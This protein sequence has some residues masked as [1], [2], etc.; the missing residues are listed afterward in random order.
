MRSVRPVR[1]R[2]PRTEPAHVAEDALDAAVVADPHLDAALDQ[3]L[4][5]VGL[6]VGEADRE[7]RV[8]ARMSSTFA[9][10]NAETFGF[11]RR[12]RGGRTVNPEMPTMRCSSP[13]AYN[14]SVGS[15]VKQ[16]IRWRIHGCISGC[17][18]GQFT[19]TNTKGA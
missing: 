9:L 16:T 14:T 2:R 19:C 13:R 1:L 11:S 5:D 4:C 7:V 17:T 12:A 15:S 10:V 3:R 18:A 8:S 6:D